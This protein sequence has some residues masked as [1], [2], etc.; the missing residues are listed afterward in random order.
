MT[1]QPAARAWPPPP[2]AEVIATASATVGGADADARAGLVNLLEQ[3]RDVRRLGGA[4]HVDE[5]LAGARLLPGLGQHGVGQ[6]G[7][8][9]AA[10]AALPDAGQHQ[11][12]QRERAVRLVD[13]EG[14]VDGG[15][16]RAG[17]QQLGGDPQGA[18]RDVRVR[19]GVGVLRRCRSGAPWPAPASIATPSSGSSSATISQVAAAVGS[20]R[21]RGAEAGVADVVVDVG[22]VGPSPATSAC[23]VATLPVRARSPA[24]TITATSGSSPGR[25][26]PGRCAAGRRAAEAADPRITTSDG[27]A[28]SFRGDGDGD[29]RAQRV[30][31]R[32][33]V[34]DGRDPLRLAEQRRRPPS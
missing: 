26:A 16:R 17:L 28:H 22:H 18:R 10:V 4:Q 31:V 3:D 25:S 9:N 11:A 14:A 20:T 2:K 12:P 24:S 1:V 7:E 6:G 19:E 30:R 33:L 23:S 34:A 8:D 15:Q 32:V 13:V 27:L 21:Y 29:G 5:S